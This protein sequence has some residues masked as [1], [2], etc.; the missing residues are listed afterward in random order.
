MSEQNPVFIPGPTN[1]TDVFHKA[2]DIVSMDH[3][4]SK[5]Q[6]IFF[7]IGHLGSLTDVMALFGIATS[8]MALV[9]LSFPVSLGSGVLAAQEYYRKSAKTRRA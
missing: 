5:L 2:C 4:S 8:E 3:R 7:R 6:E 1:I 9:D